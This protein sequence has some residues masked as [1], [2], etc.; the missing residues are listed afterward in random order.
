MSDVIMTADD[1]AR[2]TQWLVDSATDYAAAR[3]DRDRAEHML[4]VV[5]SLVMKSC[6]ETAVSAQE[7][8]AYASS[9]YLEQIE[10]IRTATIEFEKLR[11]LREAASH[12]LEFW[13]SYNATLNKAERGM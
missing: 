8:E 3:A 13:R 7:R 6:G 11:A 9:E 1:A 10:T 4:R 5:K 12:R 2:A